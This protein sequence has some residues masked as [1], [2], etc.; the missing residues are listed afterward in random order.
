MR[1]PFYLLVIF[2]GISLQAGISVQAAEIQEISDNGYEMLGTY[3]VQKQ[4][5]VSRNL[6]KLAS[7]V[8][9][10]ELTLAK[11]LLEICRK[12]TAYKKGII[13]DSA[14]K[15]IVQPL[16]VS[17]DEDVMP[18]EMYGSFVKETGQTKS[19]I[20][21]T[22]CFAGKA[23]ELPTPLSEDELSD[24][25]EKSKKYDTTLMAFEMVENYNRLTY[26]DEDFDILPA[27]GKIANT[28][29]DV[30]AFSVDEDTTGF[31]WAPEDTLSTHSFLCVDLTTMRSKDIRY[32]LGY[33]LDK[34][35][36][37]LGNWISLIDSVSPIHFPAKMI[38]ANLA[39][40]FNY[41][42]PVVGFARF[43]V[44]SLYDVYKFHIDGQNHINDFQNVL[45]SVFQIGNF[46]ED[47]IFNYK[48]LKLQISGDHYCQFY[49][50]ANEYVGD[51]EQ[52]L[53]FDVTKIKVQPIPKD[54]KLLL[55][56]QYVYNYDS[57]LCTS[58]MANGAEAM[59][60]LD[61]CRQLLY[62]DE[63]VSC[64]AIHL[65]NPP[66]FIINGDRIWPREEIESENEECKADNSECQYSLD[67]TSLKLIPSTFNAPKKEREEVISQ[68]Y[69]YLLLGVGVLVGILAFAIIGIVM[70]YCRRY[71]CPWLIWRRRAPVPEQ[72]SVFRNDGV[73][74]N[75]FGGQ[76][77]ARMVNERKKQLLAPSAPPPP[78]I[79]L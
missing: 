36:R 65:E 63:A 68:V 64:P 46:F 41:S 51:C 14:E 11:S 4:L 48:K 71:K 32:T 45:S 10:E 40:S 73:S 25:L 69:L 26:L 39:E 61:C 24:F 2:L 16:E 17:K 79:A 59:L 35:N 22:A 29:K 43:A 47:L 60:P 37:K 6:Y 55:Y 74:L 66:D 77:F 76:Y 23:K 78:P 52:L 8:I 18:Y 70:L 15:S 33:M 54:G 30:P 49:K 27:I 67:D 20:S 31:V 50:T 72:Q 58:E 53:D 9:P 5:P 21:E 3:T 38:D 1:I 19:K 44:E 13:M 57:Q 42:Y 56:D 34:V 12:V 28:V 7:T 62:L 75:D